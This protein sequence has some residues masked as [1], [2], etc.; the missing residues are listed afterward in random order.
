MTGPLYVSSS[1]VTH[2]VGCRTLHPDWRP[3]PGADAARRH[4]LWARCCRVCRPEQPTADPGPLPGNV[5]P[6]RRRAQ[7]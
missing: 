4:L 7:P 2:T 5:I 3:S 6:F 1:G